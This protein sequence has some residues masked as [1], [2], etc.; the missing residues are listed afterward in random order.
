MSAFE[1]E[2]RSSFPGSGEW[3]R[4][5]REVDL[6]PEGR[7][8]RDA[9]LRVCLAAQSRRRAR[10]LILHGVSVLL[11]LS[12]VFLGV[13]TMLTEARRPE[14]PGP[15]LLSGSGPSVLVSTGPLRESPE[16][17]PAAVGALAALRLEHVQFSVVEDEP[18]LLQRMA[19]PSPAASPALWAEDEDFLGLLGDSGLPSGMLRIDGRLYV[20]GRVADLLR[21]RVQGSE[22]GDESLPTG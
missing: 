3:E 18:A 12:A 10:G 4:S 14:L 9:I 5:E 19:L 8:R 16:S 20:T 11:L 13:W 6:S 15:E 7:R 21:A 22:F 2:F 1:P 17:R